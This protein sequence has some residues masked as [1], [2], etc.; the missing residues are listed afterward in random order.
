MPVENKRGKTKIKK[1]KKKNF[2]KFIFGPKKG[3]W[4]RGERDNK[5]YKIIVSEEKN[6]ANLFLQCLNLDPAVT[7]REL[8]IQKKSSNPYLKTVYLE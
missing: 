1:G 2:Y 4:E 6:G 3:S 5:K 8:Q 7:F